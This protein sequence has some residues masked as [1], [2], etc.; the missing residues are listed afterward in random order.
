MANIPIPLHKVWDG[1][2]V[3]PR[4]MADLVAKAEAAEHPAAPNEKVRTRRRDVTTLASVLAPWGPLHRLYCDDVYVARQVRQC[5][6]L[7]ERCVL[8][9]LTSV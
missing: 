6:L 4:T 3:S 1:L 5:F 8:L 9:V 7:R 2:S